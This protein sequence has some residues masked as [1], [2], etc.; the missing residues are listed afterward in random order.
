MS[1]G[2]TNESERHQMSAYGIKTGTKSQF[3]PKKVGK[4]YMLI[5]NNTK[6]FLIGYSFDSKKE[7]ES[8]PEEKKKVSES[9]A[10]EMWLVALEDGVIEKDVDFGTY[11]EMLED[12]DYEIVYGE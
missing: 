9:D 8:F 5:D 4:K 12:S 11:L 3:T 2:W 7:A 10:K 6:Q 1:K